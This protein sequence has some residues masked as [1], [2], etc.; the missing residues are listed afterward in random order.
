MR[1]VQPSQMTI[2]EVDISKMTFNLKSRDDIPKILKGLQF[3]YLN[4]LLRDAIFALLIKRISPNV[5]KTNG[6]P[7]MSLWT[8]FVCG[9][10]RLDLNIDY[11]RLLELMNEHRSLRM[12]L[13]HHVYN[14]EAYHM[15]TVK[16]NV[17][18][19]TPEL[20]DEINGGVSR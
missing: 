3:I 9:I 6:R 10:L 16:D 20:L 18:L 17:C 4:T 7:G 15:Q 8:I 13:G 2:G 11:D 19:F 14:D 5:S 1:V 12:I